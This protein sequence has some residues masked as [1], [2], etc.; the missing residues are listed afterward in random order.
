AAVLADVV[1]GAVVARLARV[2]RGRRRRRWLGLCGRG[3]FGERSGRS[4]RFGIQLSERFVET[5]LLVLLQAARVLFFNG[6][7]ETQPVARVP[8]EAL[9]VS[10][11][12][13]GQAV[14]R[15]TAEIGVARVFVRRQRISV[16]LE[17]S[18]QREGVRVLV[19]F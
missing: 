16:A 18:E 12:D 8:I 9:V 6:A 11:F 17:G 4:V 2:A 19:V 5:L 15:H 13:A 14:V 1:V 3:R 10:P 7:G